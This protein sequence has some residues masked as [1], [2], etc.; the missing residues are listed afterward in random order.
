M[1]WSVCL[2][3]DIT[4]RQ[5]HCQVWFP[6]RL[7]SEIIGQMKKAPALYNKRQQLQ[8][9]LETHQTGAMELSA[10]LQVKY[11]DAVIMEE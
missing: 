3:A 1:M 10:A 2:Q 8:R 11:S 9:A 6:Y 7:I 4:S 5:G